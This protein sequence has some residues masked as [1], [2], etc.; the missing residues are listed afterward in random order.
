MKKIIGLVLVFIL[1]FA[2]AANAFAGGKPKITKQPET[3]T[4]KKGGTVSF[5][6]KTSGTVKTITWYFVNPATGESFTGKQL[7]GAVEGVKVQNPNKKKITLSKVPETLH[8]WTVYAHVNGNGYKIDSDQ[9]QLLIAGME[10]AQDA[11]AEAPAAEEPPAEAPPAEES[12]AEEPPAE[13]PPAEVQPAEPETQEP[14]ANEE[15]GEVPPSG[16]F[17]VTATSSVLKRLD[18]AGNVIVGDPVSSLDFEDYGDVLVTSEEPII[19]W[20]L[21]GIRVQPDQPV[22]EFRITNITS[23]LLIDVKV[24]HASA[25]D[26]VVD[27]ANMCKVT[28]RGCTFSY[29]RGRLI[30]ATEG[31]VPAGA[32]TP[33]IFLREVSTPTPSSFAKY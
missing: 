12:P 4:V 7:A 11:P 1:V 19:S 10:T 15:A 27:T 14:A 22:K 3:A 32:P 20:T 33:V 5:S 26:I 2:V 25:A 21:N 24:Q 6:I 28:C 8:G 23:S 16:P 29:V 18:E 17:T 30:S 13:E 31:E 9:V